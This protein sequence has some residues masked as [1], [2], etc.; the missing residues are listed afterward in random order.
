M[1][2]KNPLVTAPRSKASGNGG[3]FSSESSN[4]AV[5]NRPRP[6]APGAVGATPRDVQPL[7]PRNVTNAMSAVAAKRDVIYDQLLAACEAEDA[8]ALVLKSYPF[9]SP[10]W[11]KLECWLPYKSIPEMTDRSSVLITIHPKPFHRYEYVFDIQ[12]QDGIKQR[13]YNSV[14]VFNGEEA[15]EVVRHVLRR[16]GSR[17][18][19]FH[20]LRLREKRWQFWRVQNKVARIRP[21]HLPQVAKAMIVIGFFTLHIPWLGFPLMLGG[22]ALAFYNWRRP[23]YD[24]SGGKPTQ[25]PRILTPWAR[26]RTLIPDLASKASDLKRDLKSEILRA[27][28]DETI[29]VTE[30]RIWYWGIDGKVEREQTVL[31]FRRGIAF[32][33][34]YAYNNDLSV[35]WDCHINTG[36]WIEYVATS[37]VD[38]TTGEFVRVMGIRSAHHPTNEYEIADVDCLTEWVHSAVTNVVKRYVEEH[39]IDV[40]IDFKID[41]EKDDR[42]GRRNQDGGEGDQAGALPKFRSFLKRLG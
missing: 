7:I 31:N 34:I 8:R 33:Q 25:E 16:T 4:A 27:N 26:W 32:V 39:K 40:Q 28:V 14:G 42:Y 2:E 18:P 6:S 9:V 23:G 13:T 36:T 24:L 1:D 29:G 38:P 15:R 35:R 21:N 12:V 11:V 17:T 3:R 41:R 37:G 30:E 20:F 19:A 5:T 22:A 10:A